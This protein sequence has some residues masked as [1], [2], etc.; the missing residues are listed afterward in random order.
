MPLQ[1]VG[2][3]LICTPFLQM[4]S[5]AGKAILP[6]PASKPQQKDPFTFS[7]SPSKSDKPPHHSSAV[8]GAFSQTDASRRLSSS[9]EEA[10][11]LI[12][13]EQGSSA[14][15]EN[16]QGRQT[17]QHGSAQH[18]KSQGAKHG[19]AK[20]KVSSGIAVALG[21]ASTQP[22]AQQDSMA[23]PSSVSMQHAES[24]RTAAELSRLSLAKESHPASSETQQQAELPGADSGGAA[25]IAQDSH[26][27]ELASAP[28]EAALKPP[29]GS[30]SGNV[31]AG[32]PEIG[33]ADH[34][35]SAKDGP[36]A[37]EDATAAKMPGGQ[38]Q[39]VSM[40]SNSTYATGSSSSSG[41]RRA[42]MDAGLQ[43]GPVF[44]PIVLTMDDTDHELLVEEWLHR[45]AVSA[46]TWFL[47]CLHI[48]SNRMVGW[49]LMPDASVIQY[50]ELIM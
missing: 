28:Q 18:D 17:E 48:H 14:T 11:Q 23:A 30:A 42:S 39:T 32:N 16:W 10:A 29:L 3:M 43:P 27:G 19:C 7:V 20:Q 13:S 1:D 37:A 8:S 45:Q 33:K 26:R 5:K 12:R 35:A 41:R 46:L 34:S 31:H 49:G 9:C 24:T 44:V 25:S 21:S 6:R 22:G 40:S 47:M 50:H 36:P 38:A 4:A 15:I 2:S